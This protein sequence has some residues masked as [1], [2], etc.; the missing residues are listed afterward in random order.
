[1]QRDWAYRS[2][3]LWIF[4]VVFVGIFLI[5]AMYIFLLFLLDPGSFKPSVRNDLGEI[6][7][8]EHQ[9]I[10]RYVQAFNHR[11]GPVQF[12]DEPIVAHKYHKSSSMYVR[13]IPT[14]VYELVYG[15]EAKRY[16]YPD[17]L[18]YGSITVELN[19]GTIL[20]YS[21]PKVNDEIEEESMYLSECGKLSEEQ[22]FTKIL[23][24]LDYYGLSTS[25][26]D[27]LISS[28]TGSS[29]AGDTGHKISF[30][31]E[32]KSNKREKES[33]SIHICFS[34]YTGKIWLLWYF[35]SKEQIES[36]VE[37]E[38]QN[39]INNPNENNGVLT[40]QEN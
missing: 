34:G 8:A 24:L 20:N 38:K 40:S 12:P 9:L 35:P 37:M 32:I 2:A 39:K 30:D 36:W 26:V 25:K 6:T 18:E 21:S 7:P 4:G 17:I 29:W 16:G 33:A 1:M 13:C 11:F 14:T 28:E 19:S 10:K 22:T 3:T 23:P 31:Y 27:Y 15:K 5:V